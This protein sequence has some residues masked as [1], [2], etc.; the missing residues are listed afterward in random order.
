MRPD[1]YYRLELPVD[2]E[3][4]LGLV[5]RLRD[6]L[7]KVLQYERTLCPFQRGFSV[8][9]PEAPERRPRKPSAH[10]RGPAK[11]WKLEGVWRPEGGDVRHSPRSSDTESTDGDPGE[12][13]L[14]LDL[15]RDQHTPVESQTDSDVGLR[16]GVPIRPGSLAG[17]RSLTAPPQLTTTFSPPSKPPVTVIRE[18]TIEETD[19]TTRTTLAPL[20][21][22]GLPPTP[23]SLLDKDLSPFTAMTNPEATESE[24]TL[25]PSEASPSRADSPATV[26][27]E[28][29]LVVEKRSE[30]EQTIKAERPAH[31]L[32][33]SGSAARLREFSRGSR[34]AP[35]NA[36]RQRRKKTPSSTSLASSSSD[37]AASRLYRT[38]SSES[39]RALANG[40]VQKTCAIVLGPPAN[41]VSL[42][43]RI[44]ARFAKGAMDITVHS[45]AGSHRKVPGSW[46]L[47]E[48]EDDWD[49]DD[50][51]FPIAK[52]SAVASA[53]SG[54]GKAWQIE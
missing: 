45:P 2:S 12:Q 50:Y 52:T 40:I 27:N 25:E 26:Q 14:L 36:V 22:S 43:L 17:A 47:S 5:E 29:P 1:T 19:N 9:L 10:I 28:G 34:D 49:I 24:N 51:G 7:R 23:D 39:Q 38:R 42:M 8:D 53:Q 32:K 11:R 46:D 18:E 33:E 41:L 48:D 3:E 16:P 30:P 44:A 54:L 37:S 13:D 4:D 20:Q 6:T 21:L 15:R 31:V 35:S